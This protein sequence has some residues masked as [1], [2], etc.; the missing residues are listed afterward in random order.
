MGQRDHA[1]IK[2]EAHWFVFPFD[3]FLPPEAVR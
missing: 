3:T 2:V 1:S